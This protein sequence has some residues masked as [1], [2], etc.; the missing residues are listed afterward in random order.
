[1][2]TRPFV[3]TACTRHG[4]VHGRNTAVYTAR[5]RPS[6][7]PYAAVYTT[8]YSPCMCRVHL[9]TVCTRPCTRAVYIVCRVHGPCTYTDRVHTRPCRPIYTAVYTGHVY[10]HGPYTAVYGPCTRPCSRPV[11]GLVMLYTRRW[12][13]PVYTAVKTAVYTARVYGGV[14]GLYMAVTVTRLP[15]I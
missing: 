12:T 1:M 11:H 9:Y 5:T 15:P 10:V 2:Y 13:L 14:D 7:G 3:Y 6:T 4:R 8:G